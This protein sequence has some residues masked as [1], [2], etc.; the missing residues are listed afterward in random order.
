[1]SV[2][3][4]QKEQHPQVKHRRFQIY[5]DVHGRKWEAPIDTRTFAPVAPLKPRGWSAPVKGGLTPERYIR[6]SQDLETPFALTIDYAR[7]IGDYKESYTEWH[8]LLVREGRRMLKGA[9]DPAN[10]AQQ[11]L[12]VVGPEPFPW[13]YWEACASPQ[14]EGHRWALGLSDERP[15]WADRWFAPKPT[16]AEFLYAPKAAAAP[17][18]AARG[19]EAH[20]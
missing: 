4:L 3:L 6:Y 19:V 13:Q 5:T 17:R 16:G 20:G 9:F 8:K 15:S 10:P 18:K 14:A 11:V 12:D 1:M 7:L 2:V